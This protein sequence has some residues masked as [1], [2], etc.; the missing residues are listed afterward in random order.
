[1]YML[2]PE[3][4]C[5]IRNLVSHE[6]F[7]SYCNDC[8][9]DMVYIPDEYTS[10]IYQIKPDGSRE[11]LARGDIYIFSTAGEWLFYQLTINDSFKREFYML[12]VG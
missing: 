4:T 12:K 6:E 2:K 1:M 11:E 5:I 10:V 9:I 3:I 8:V 7:D